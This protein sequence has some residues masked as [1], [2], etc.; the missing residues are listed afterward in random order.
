MVIG[1]GR[2]IRNMNACFEATK[3]ITLDVITCSKNGML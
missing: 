3:P 1:T 2:A